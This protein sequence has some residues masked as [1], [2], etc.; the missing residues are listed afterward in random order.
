MRSGLIAVKYAGQ[1]LADDFLEKALTDYNTALG[2]AVAEGGKVETLIFDPAET[3]LLSSA[4]EAQETFKDSPLF[5]HFYHADD[6][7]LTV[8]SL[9][10][11]NIISNDK[12]EVLLSVM[13]E[14]EGFLGLTDEEGK[15]HSNEW[16]AVQQILGDQLCDLYEE[17]GSDLAKLLTELDKPEFRKEL[18]ELL[19]PRGQLHVIPAEGKPLGFIVDDKNVGKEFS[20]GYVSKTLGYTE[21]VAKV[22]K[23]EPPKKMSFKDRIAQAKAGTAVSGEAKT[24]VPTVAA[25]DDTNKKEIPK[26]TPLVWKGQGAGGTTYMG[27]TK[28]SDTNILWC[29]PRAGAG[30]KEA[31]H[32]WNSN[33]A[34]PR[35]KDDREIFNGFPATQLKAQCAVRTAA[36]N[37]GL[38]EPV[39]AM[40]EAMSKAQSTTKTAAAAVDKK[41]DKVDKEDATPLIIPADEKKALA[42][43]IAGMPT[44]DDANIEKELG[45]Y[46]KFT[47]LMAVPFATVIR[48]RPSAMLR[49]E[50]RSLVNLNNE[51]RMALY[52]ANPKAFE[53]KVE[54]KE[55]TAPATSEAAPEKKPTFAERI[56]AA[57]SKAA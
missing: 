32:Y 19:L 47:E 52:K 28:Q 27:K 10:P 56:A 22:E 8:E 35:P 50:K 18:R 29:K 49:L 37:L 57:K 13:L 39:T 12:D 23:P 44:M 38:I 25:S 1:K 31:I 21:E 54:T 51:L 11:F 9:Q 7:E 4:L 15:P 26:E 20:W 6:D 3:D 24:S 42:A 5:M 43:I 40:R 17:N 45:A 14:G 30:L 46:P 33:C 41:D 36:E 55:E 34:I 2:I 48:W 53:L 16:L